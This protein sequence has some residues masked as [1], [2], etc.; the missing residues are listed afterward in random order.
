MPNFFIK[1]IGATFLT[2]CLSA[3]AGDGSNSDSTTVTETKKIKAI[4]VGAGIAGL[5]AAHDL[6]AQGMDVTVLEAQEKVGGRLKVNRSL[7]LPFDEGAS[8]IHGS[9]SNH[10][11]TKLA[12]VSGLKLFETLDD[13]VAIYDTNGEEYTEQVA[14]SANTL[15]E[16][17]LD[18]VRD[19][20][21]TDRSFKSVFDE[22]SPQFYNNRIRDYMLSAYLEFNIG[23]DITKLSSSEF[24][25]DEAFDGKEQL[26]TNGYDNLA[27]YFAKDLNV[28]TKAIINR[29]DYSSSLV[30]VST[31]DGKVY[32]A[33]KV[34]VA[35]P[36]GVLK[37][38]KIKFIPDLPTYKQDVINRMHMGNVN[39][40]LVKWDKTFWDNQLQ[41]IGYTAD[42]KGRF[43]YFLN[44]NKFAPN[45]NALMTFAFGDE[46]DV[47]EK[48]TDDQIINEIVTNL[49]NIYGDAV[50]QQKPK[51]LR[52]KWRENQFTFGA[53]SFVGVGST[54]ND[55]A[56]IAAPV[57]N[58]IYFAGEHTSTEYRGTVHGAYLSG[59]RAAKQISGLVK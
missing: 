26:V 8:W 28:I 6:K 40:F 2:T 24:D 49:R 55:F 39:K 46:A 48:Q 21:S 37:K 51:L 17:T 57:Q 44:V 38:N 52:T 7:G 11:I 13:N 50:P 58:K 1:I 33:D 3:C 25:T 36:L 41:Y 15:F 59:E 34:V 29:I 10:P 9:N 30:K 31:T 45:S 20:G 32:E 43:N 53:Y 23:G 47:T 4:V 12:G 5:K 19:E 54:T 56:T 14:N 35:V 42:A 22:I 16:N 18:E 27:L